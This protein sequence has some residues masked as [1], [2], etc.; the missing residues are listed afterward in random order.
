MRSANTQRCIMEMEAKLIGFNQRS[1]IQQVRTVDWPRFISSELSEADH[2]HRSNIANTVSERVNAHLFFFQFQ[3]PAQSTL[4]GYRCMT[5]N[6]GIYAER[7]YGP[8]PW[9]E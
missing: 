3:H 7:N 6:A 1:T 2:E 9:D 5:H 4:F 8:V